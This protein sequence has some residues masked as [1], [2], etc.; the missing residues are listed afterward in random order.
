MSSLNIFSVW[1][2][3]S[4]LTGI[5][6]MC[7]SHKSSERT[8]AGC[9]V[10]RHRMYDSSEPCCTC[11]I[12]NFSAKGS[13][14]IWISILPH[15]K[16]LICCFIVVVVLFWERLVNVRS[17]LVLCSSAS[18]FC[19]KLALCENKRPSL[20]FFFLSRLVHFYFFYSPSMYNNKLHIAN[21]EWRSEWKMPALMIFL[22]SQLDRIFVRSTTNCW[23]CRC[24]RFRCL[25]M[26]IDSI[27]SDFLIS[28]LMCA[29]LNI[30][31]PDPERT[32]VFMSEFLLEHSCS[33]S[34]SFVNEQL[35][36][37]DFC[38]SRIFS[39]SFRKMGLY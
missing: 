17:Q 18:T 10:Y 20:F 35:K 26:S 34:A 29:I 33:L 9:L 32:F 4:W 1:N 28:I 14:K 3:C 24:S 31:S 13:D 12:P 19:W 27:A 36:P 38:S 23:S 22:R 16:L 21:N 39:N 2:H 37:N 15:N 30:Y 25:Y 11:K 7:T 5:V 6:C 8:S